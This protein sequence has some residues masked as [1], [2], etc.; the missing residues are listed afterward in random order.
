MLIL[1]VDLF[2]IINFN[3]TCFTHFTMDFYLVLEICSILF[4]SFLLNLPV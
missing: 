1:I 2:F 3:E 4:G